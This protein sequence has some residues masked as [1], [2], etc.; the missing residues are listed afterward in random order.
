MRRKRQGSTQ[1]S[2]QSGATP[3]GGGEPLLPAA[4][5]MRLSADYAGQG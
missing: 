2:W 4:R 1:L 3:P 5:T